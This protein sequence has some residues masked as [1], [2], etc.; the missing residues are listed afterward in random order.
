VVYL[1]AGLLV[2][3]V[4]LGALTW[5]TFTLIGFLLTLAVAGL[6]GWAADA[7]V[8]GRLPGGW[9]GAVL[10][11]IIGGFIGTLLLGRIGPT[12]FD[13]NIIPAFIGAAVIAVV[14]ELV[15]GSRST[16]LR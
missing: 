5:F 2:L 3:A 16:V 15:V 4:V 1:L 12:I 10:A 14:A 8:P 13:V 9:L 7:V 6:V 11:G